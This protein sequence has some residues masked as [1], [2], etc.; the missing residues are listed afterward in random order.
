[1]YSSYEVD[2]CYIV[3]PPNKKP[4]RWGDWSDESSGVVSHSEG[5]SGGIDSGRRPERDIQCDRPQAKKQHGQFGA[6]RRKHTPTRKQ[7]RPRNF[8]DEGRELVVWHF[9]LGTAKYRILAISHAF[10]SFAAPLPEYPPQG[11]VWLDWKR[12]EINQRLI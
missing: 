6:Q 3:E 11:N 5:V 7:G 9:S 1:M 8:D 4:E 10:A 12:G 2:D